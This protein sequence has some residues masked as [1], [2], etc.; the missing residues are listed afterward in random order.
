MIRDGAACTCIVLPARSASHAL[1]PL[2]LFKLMALQAAIVRKSHG[3]SGSTPQESVASCCITY[4]P[5]ARTPHNQTCG[6]SYK[7]IPLVVA[8]WVSEYCLQ[9]EGSQ[10]VSSPPIDG[11]DQWGSS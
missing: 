8:R 7:T 2:E 4:A 5:I 9:V 6:R 10:R 3:S 1:L 11:D